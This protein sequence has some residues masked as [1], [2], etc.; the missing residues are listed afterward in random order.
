M[1]AGNELTRADVFNLQQREPTSRQPR[2]DIEGKLWS[3]NELKKLFTQ[4]IRDTQ[5]EKSIWEETVKYTTAKLCEALHDLLGAYDGRDP[6]TDGLVDLETN[7][8]VIRKAQAVLAE[9]E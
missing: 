9:V 3:L 4:A 6:E 2:L 8:T 5:A 7:G 1:K